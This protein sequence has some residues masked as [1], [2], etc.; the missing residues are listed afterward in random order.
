M[1]IQEQQIIRAC[2]SGS[3]INLIDDVEELE[4]LKKIIDRRIDE[5]S[6]EG[7]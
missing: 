5:I 2:I 7:D 3:L 1:E 4:L 6:E